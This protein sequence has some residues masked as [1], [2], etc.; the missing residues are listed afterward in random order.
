[1]KE[2]FETMNNRRSNTKLVLLTFSVLLTSLV[3]GQNNKNANP[4]AL[5]NQAVELIGKQ[6]Y[7]EA[8]I[9]LEKSIQIKPDYAEAIF[10]KGTCLLM[11]NKRSQAC[12]DFNLALRYNHQQASEY[13]QKYCKR[14]PK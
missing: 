10:A 13:I 2:E 8:V 11:L 9:L 3:F 12:D 5:Y 4:G 6:S 1:M 14:Q 7:E